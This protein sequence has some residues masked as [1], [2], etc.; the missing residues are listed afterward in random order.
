MSDPVIEQVLA[1]LKQVK[2]TGHGWSAQCPGHDDHQNSL[3]IAEGQE[4]RVLLK[5]FAGCEVTQIVTAAGLTM[6]DL[7]PDRRERGGHPPSQ[8]DNRATG[9]GC[10]LAQYSEAKRLP[11][12]FLGGLG[13][14]DTVYQS[15]PAIRIPYRNEHGDEIAVRYRTALAKSDQDD[16]RFR[17]KQGA[18]PCLYGLWRLEQIRAAGSVVVVEGESDAQTLWLH[19]IRALGLPGAALWQEAWAQHFDGIATIYVVVEPDAG[20]QAVRKWLATSTIRDRVRLLDFKEAKDP[21]QLYL[22]DPQRFLETWHSLQ[23]LATPYREVVQREAEV[24][25]HEA[26]AHCHALAQHPRIL[27]A[28][29]EV[30]PQLGVAREERAAMLLYLVLM[31]RVLKKPVSAIVKGPSSAGKSY[32]V[33]RV[34]EFFPPSAAYALSA[35]SERALAYSKEPLAHRVLV[36]Y[37]ATALQGE[38][39]TYLIRSL[40]SEGCIRYETVEKTKKGMEP[41][42][43]IREGPTSLLVTTTAIKLHPEN[44]TRMLSILLSDTPEQTRH[45]LLAQAEERPLEVDLTP[46]RAL[47][48][49]LASDTSPVTIP[50]ATAL[51]QAIP[52]VAVRLRR[53]FGALLNLIRAHTVLHQATRATTA[54]GAL[55][56]TLDDYAA[57]RELIADLVA[58]GADSS[59]PV[60]IRETVEAVRILRQS[61]VADISQARVAKALH[62]DKGAT[63]RRIRAAIERGYLTNLE[64]RKGRPAKLQLGD[65]LP[66]DV[67]VLPSPETLKGDCCT[68][69]QNP[70]G[71][72]SLSPSASTHARTEQAAASVSEP[73]PPTIARDSTGWPSE[74]RGLGP[75]HTGPME[76]CAQC[77]EVTWV[78]YGGKALCRGHAVKEVV[79]AARVDRDAVPQTELG[80]FDMVLE[81]GTAQDPSPEERD[82]A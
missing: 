74:I 59:V 36:L 82:G 9:V 30:L 16:Q 46:W 28:F 48:T 27:D 22:A 43:I 65:S 77:Q 3:S 47:Q 81:L 80:L 11:L 73:P 37:E 26:W 40:L 57:V 24:E 52:P 20:G 68:V 54:E 50:Y 38:L 69:A 7:F 15:R 10:T 62:L 56:A 61:S 78:S 8:H 5:C 72:V 4:G 41:R 55:I 76:C 53:D 17:W 34:L 31:S 33:E 6:T 14:S 32:L 2:Q 25:R 63:S 29:V 1:H 45:V 12:E 44:E 79:E 60:H 49:W 35:M 18:K 39:G 42:L 64:D 21:S 66:N 71:N 19:G 67:E 51:A 23:T 13:L 58:D 70:E 75:N